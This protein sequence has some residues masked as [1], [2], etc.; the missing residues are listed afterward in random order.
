MILCTTEGPALSAEELASL[1]KWVRRGGSL[2][3]L[4]FS[5]WS[6]HC[7]YAQ[8]TVGWLGITTF[9]G[10]QFR[11]HQVQKLKPLPGITTNGAFGNQ[12]V[13]DNSGETVFSLN[14]NGGDDDDDLAITSLDSGNYNVQIP[15]FYERVFGAVREV[16]HGPNMTC[17]AYA[18]PSSSSQGHVLVTS[19]YHWL[20]NNTHW[21]G[22]TW[23]SSP[24]NQTLLYNFLAK[25]LTRPRQQQ[26]PI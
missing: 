4:A 21:N 19:N 15:P 22:G 24:S 25:G 7:H 9:P 17:L 16:A 14:A 26:S 13:F 1:Q 12:T 18:P 20:A 2:I 11:R 3:V 8:A 5:N 10:A 23:T 6:A